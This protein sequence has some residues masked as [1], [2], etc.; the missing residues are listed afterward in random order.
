MDGIGDGIEDNPRTAKDAS[1]LADCTGKAVFVAGKF[2][3]SF[4]FAV[5]LLLAF[6]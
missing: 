4:A 2:K 3:G 6:L 5:N 1:S